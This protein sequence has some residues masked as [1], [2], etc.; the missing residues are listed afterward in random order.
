MN[1]NEIKKL[2]DEELYSILVSK[3]LNS[4]PITV[5][6]RSVYEKKLLKYF[7]EAKTPYTNLNANI[8]MTKKNSSKAQVNSKFQNQIEE[9][10][11]EPMD[12][13]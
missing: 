8:K 9:M 6:T 5:L 13:E 7:K 4:G 10:N 1:E 11:D 2:S 3:N 12:F